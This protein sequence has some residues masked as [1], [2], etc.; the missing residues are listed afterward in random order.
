MATSNSSSF[1]TLNA[2]ERFGAN[3]F[4]IWKMLNRVN[5]LAPLSHMDKNIVLRTFRCDWDRFWNDVPIMASPCR[6]LGDFFLRTLPWERLVTPEGNIVVHDL[7]CGSGNLSRRIAAWSGVP[8]SYY[9]FDVRARSN[10]EELMHEEPGVHLQTFDGHHF[11]STLT[12]DFDVFLSH[13]ALEHVV[14]DL[15]FFKAVQGYVKRANKPVL[16]V[17]L[18]P[19]RHCL[20]LFG[21]HGI[22]QYT[23]RTLSKI[24]RLFPDCRCSIVGLGGNACTNLHLEFVTNPLRTEK[25]DRRQAENTEYLLRLRSAIKSDVDTAVIDAHYY[26]LVIECGFEEPVL[27]ENYPVTP[28]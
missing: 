6:R 19:T 24:T 3:R 25:L 23:P 14:D 28:V 16:Q 20:Q 8:A 9:G 13:S 4:A 1:H 22:R 27:G 15:S 12:Q 2:D 5:N 21:H 18:V 7:G 17:H 10:W 26:A 11:A